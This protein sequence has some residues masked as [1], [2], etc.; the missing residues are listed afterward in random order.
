MEKLVECC[1]NAPNLHIESGILEP[2]H[3]TVKENKFF[4]DGLLK[5]LKECDQG[6]NKATKVYYEKT[7]KPSILLL[8]YK[9]YISKLEQDLLHHLQENPWVF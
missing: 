9:K 5:T 3:L 2:Q 1:V 4:V 6:I 8:N 7:G